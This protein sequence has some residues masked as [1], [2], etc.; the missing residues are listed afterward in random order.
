VRVGIALR[1]LC[2]PGLTV[3]LACSTPISLEPQVEDEEEDAGLDAGRPSDAAVRDA[4]AGT[5]PG[6][7]GPDS[8]T[9]GLFGCEVYPA[10]E[11]P[12]D[13]PGN[14]ARCS[15]NQPAAASY[16]YYSAQVAGQLQVAECKVPRAPQGESRWEVSRA[17]CSYQCATEL[18]QTGNFFSLLTDGCAARP[19]TDCHA[20]LARTS[21]EGVDRYLRDF[22]MA[23][24]L[25]ENLQLGVSINQQGCADWV[26]YQAGPRL[27]NAQSQCLSNRL[28]A[29]R[30]DCDVSCA[31][32]P[33]TA[34]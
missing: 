20:S 21:Q 29:V 19:L 12:R 18:P 13:Q 33:S 2:L 26:H 23:C 6:D 28:E 34:P 5:G 31:L 30:F 14:G 15:P 1:S 4:E 27:T 16:C 8:A 17:R 22:A 9:S 25:R 24:G 11:C 32:T 10:R 7:A 3:L